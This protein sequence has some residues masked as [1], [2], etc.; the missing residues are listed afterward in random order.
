MSNFGSSG[1]FATKVALIDLNYDSV[2]LCGI[3]MTETPHIDRPKNWRQANGFRKNWLRLSDETKS[4]I[5]SMSG[6]TKEQFGG[7]ENA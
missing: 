1:L 7:P 3:P 6:W 4:R 2:V 5:K